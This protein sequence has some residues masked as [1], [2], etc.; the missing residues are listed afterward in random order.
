MEAAGFSETSVT[1]P[2]HERVRI[3]K[4]ISETLSM[5][6]RTIRSQ[7]RRFLQKSVN[8]DTTFKAKLVI[9]TA[10]KHSDLTGV[11]YSKV[12]NTCFQVAN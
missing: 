6:L 2:F 5:I 7:I 10:L 11:Y 1:L 3:Q 4:K 9:F 12:G 8:M